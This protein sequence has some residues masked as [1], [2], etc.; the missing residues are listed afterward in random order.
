MVAAF[1]NLNASGRPVARMV[2]AGVV[3]IAMI[4]MSAHL[5]VVQHWANVAIRRLR[6]VV[7]EMHNAQRLQCVLWASVKTIP[8]SI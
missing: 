1:V 4:T 7:L 5:T 6:G 8:A 2:V 3:A